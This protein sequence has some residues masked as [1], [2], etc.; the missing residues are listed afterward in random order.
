MDSQGS[1][2][3]A[4]GP[5]SE[6]RG[7][8]MAAHLSA[9]IAVIGFPFGHVVGP[10]VV[11][12]AK[13]KE[14]PYV[15]AHARASMNYQITVSLAALVAI[16]VAVVLFVVVVG[17]AGLSGSHHEASGQAAGIGFIALWAAAIFVACTFIIASLIFIIMGTVAA[18]EGRPYTYP[19]A[20]TFIR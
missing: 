10:L 2:A 16:A 1:T 14:S 13:A 6:E 7:W 15:A 11:Y 12:L 17:F 18:S 5:T 4:T 9:L 20:I 8:A 19:F 3:L